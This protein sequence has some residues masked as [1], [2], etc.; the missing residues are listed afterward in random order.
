V[1]RCSGRTG[2]ESRSDALDALPR[3]I[4]SFKKLFF[5]LLLACILRSVRRS[6]LIA[7]QGQAAGDST[8]FEVGHTSHYYRSRRGK[9]HFYVP[10]WPKLTACIDIASHF[11][12]SATVTVGP[13]RDTI[14]APIVLRK[15][16]RRV[17]FRRAI[18]DAGCDSESFHEMVRHELHA[19]SV[20]PVKSGRRTRR[21]PPTQYRRQMKRRFL[22][23]IYR[24][25]WQIESVFS[26]HK[27]RLSSELR[28]K[29]W[30]A[31]QA[32]IRLRVLLH[33]LML[34]AT[35]SK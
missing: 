11:F 30:P 31:Q 7:L 17:G 15:A 18:W 2:T 34:L 21:W 9:K 26:R 4:A 33:N 32:E 24:Q 1:V 5:E 25:R 20:V 6:R 28:A 14:E 8:G 10:R 19:H 13:S 22:K 12:L 27:R 3:R 35:V 23:R 29:T 16:H